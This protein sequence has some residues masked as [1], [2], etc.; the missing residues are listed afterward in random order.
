L[1]S[2]EIDPEYS[3]AKKRLADV[4]RVIATQGEQVMDANL[5]L[6]T[7]SPSNATH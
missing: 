7:Q 4:E 1:R 5:P 2:L 3:I 6:A